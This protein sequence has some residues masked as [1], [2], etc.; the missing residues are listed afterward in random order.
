MTEGR[1]ID[2]GVEGFDSGRPE[3]HAGLACLA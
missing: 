3:Q 1:E 2:L